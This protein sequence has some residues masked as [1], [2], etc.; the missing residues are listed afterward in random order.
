MLHLHQGQRLDE[1]VLPPLPEVR[2]PRREQGGARSGAH[3]ELLKSET[4]YLQRVNDDELIYLALYWVNG[5]SVTQGGE[6]EKDYY[7]LCKKAGITTP[8]EFN[9][10]WI[11]LRDV[12]ILEGNGGSEYITID[13][14]ESIEISQRDPRIKKIF[15]LVKDSD[16][17]WTGDYK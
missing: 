15:D 7:L 6:W 4:E 14:N 11:P 12:G 16:R 3:F 10:H 17:L 9:A 13:G 2:L 8:K 1:K 5:M